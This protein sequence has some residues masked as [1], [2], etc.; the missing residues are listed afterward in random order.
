MQ[1]IGFIIAACLALAV[2]RMLVAIVA[3]ACIATLLLGMLLRPRETAGYFLAAAGISLLQNYP[4]P[5]L[6]AVCALVYFQQ[7]AHHAR[8]PP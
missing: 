7:P 8:S 1:L 3:V 2:L 5:T 6:C 4:L